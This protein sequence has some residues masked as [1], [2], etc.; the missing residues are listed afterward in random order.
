MNGKEVFHG[1]IFSVVQTEMEIQ[2]RMVHRD[3]VIHHGGVAMACVQDG[4]ILLV[5]QTRAGAGCRTLEIP[6][7]TLEPHEDPRTC[8]MR[9]LNEEAGLQADHMELITATW[10]TPGYDTEV[11]YIYACSG[12][13]PVQSRL[14][15]D[16]GEDI[17]LVWM[18]LE[19]AWQAVTDQKIRDAK[20]VIAILDARLKALTDRSAV[21]KN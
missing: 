15:M 8:G 6:A 21:C 7:G 2:G 10:P 16:E 12:L 18:D 1:K 3:L 5:S 4:K 11:I 17:E 9:E 14:P 20:T 13:H 19:E